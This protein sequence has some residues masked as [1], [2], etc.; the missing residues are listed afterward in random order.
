MGNFNDSGKQKPEI[1][2]NF[3]KPKS[4]IKSDCKPPKPTPELPFKEP[5]FKILEDFITYCSIFDSTISTQSG[6]LIDN[7]SL[8][9]SNRIYLNR[10]ILNSFNELSDIGCEI[11]EVEDLVLFICDAPFYCEKPKE[12]LLKSKNLK[13]IEER[14]PKINK[15]SIWEQL[16]SSQVHSVKTYVYFRGSVNNEKFQ[17]WLILKTPTKNAEYAISVSSLEDMMGYGNTLPEADLE[18]HKARIKLFTDSQI[19]INYFID[20]KVPL[21]KQRMFDT[22]KKIDSLVDPNTVTFSYEDYGFS[23]IE[24][25]HFKLSCQSKTH[26]YTLNVC[27]GDASWEVVRILNIE[28]R[29]YPVWLEFIGQAET[30]EEAF[31][32]C[33]SQYQECINDQENLAKTIS[34][35]QSEEMQKE[36]MMGGLDGLIADYREDIFPDRD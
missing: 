24:S 7:A 33:E 21:T 15:L 13:I 1:K 14:F 17:R 30:L 35:L 16:R 8:S 27:Q 20:K 12:Y 22:C 34:S 5:E 18:F 29:N 10:A 2:F 19:T 23:Y 25:S 4:Q 28:D 6:R 26:K 31:D 3:G 32:K 11:Q 9:V 36:L